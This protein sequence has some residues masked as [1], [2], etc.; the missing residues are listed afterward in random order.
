MSCTAQW[1]TDCPEEPTR[2]EDLCVAVRQITLL[3]VGRITFKSE[4]HPIVLVQNIQ[5]DGPVVRGPIFE[6]TVS[7]ELFREH[8]RLRAAVIAV[9]TTQG[10]R[11]L[12]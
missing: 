3:R 10:V 4:Q 5:I 12:R 2:N 8:K 11:Q 6:N 9:S 7:S 1:A